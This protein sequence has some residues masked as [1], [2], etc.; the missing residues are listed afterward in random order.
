MVVVRALAPWRLGLSLLLVAACRR[1]RGP[2]P[3]QTDFLARES[4]LVWHATVTRAQGLPVAVG[5]RCRF[6]ARVGHDPTHGALDLLFHGHCGATEVYAPLDEDLGTS[7]MLETGQRGCTLTPIA[8]DGGPRAYVVRC[9][10]HRGPPPSRSHELSVDGATA[11]LQQRWD[12]S[13]SLDLAWEP[14]SEPVVAR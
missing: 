3:V 2:R 13:G 6:E 8:N 4:T 7:A 5:A 1:P 11:H 12:A 10:P 9:P 14:A